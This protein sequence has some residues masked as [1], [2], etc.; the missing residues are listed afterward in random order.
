M[1]F[2]FKMG[3]EY[4]SRRCLDDKQTDVGTALMSA[5]TASEPLKMIITKKIEFSKR[6][7]E[8]VKIEIGF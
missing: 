7:E 1:I 3:E 6:M 8:I 4:G 2:F 5:I